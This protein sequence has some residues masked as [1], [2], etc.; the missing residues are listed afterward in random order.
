MVLGGQERKN[1]TDQRYK[2]ERS[3]AD[4]AED[5]A[6][7]LIDAASKKNNDHRFEEERRRADKA[8]DLAEALIDV[9]AKQAEV[10]LY[11]CQSAQL[12][13]IVHCLLY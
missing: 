2:E 11:N 7:V 6:E 4:K 1:N 5:L 13:K 9:A 3:R 8:E 12:H 10:S